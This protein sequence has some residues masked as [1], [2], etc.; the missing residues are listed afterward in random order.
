MAS[1][2]GANA[3][4]DANLPSRDDRWVEALNRRPLLLGLVR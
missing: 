2:F 4:A 1:T 3:M